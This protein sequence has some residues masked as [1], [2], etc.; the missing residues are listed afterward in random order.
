[1][2][3]N[4]YETLEISFGASQAVISAAYRVLSNKYHPDKNNGDKKFENI[5]ADINVAY[6]TL[7]DPVKKEIYDKLNGFKSGSSARDSSDKSP[8]VVVVPDGEKNLSW[9]MVPIVAVFMILGILAF[10]VFL[11]AEYQRLD[12]VKNIAESEV[13]ERSFSEMKNSIW[14]KAEG[15]F[16][17]D[18]VPQNFSKSLEM[19]KDIS[20]KN[21]FSDRRA[22]KRIAEIYYFGLGRERDYLEAISWYQLISNSESNFMIGYAY[23]KGLG[24]KKDLIKSY[25]H[26]N[27]S[28]SRKYELTEEFRANDLIWKE[29]SAYLKPNLQAGEEDIVHRFG[30][31]LGCQYN[32][33]FVIGSKI[34]KNFLDKKLKPEEINLAQNLK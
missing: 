12:R 6:E 33:R 10:R 9:V 25:Y 24:V 32:E 22:E 21:Y 11:D 5:M 20:A 4:Y 8:S 19:Y 14:M 1:M 2:A 30:C 3:K 18:G 29:V 17:G 27:L 16:F 7:S 23:F 31:D 26:F 15:N 13:K 28:Q 34:K